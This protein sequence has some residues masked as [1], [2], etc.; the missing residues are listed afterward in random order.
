MLL[1]EPLIILSTPRTYSLVLLHFGQVIL[2]TVIYRF[3]SVC[4]VPSR[5]PAICLNLRIL[6]VC[7]EEDISSGC[8]ER[9]QVILHIFFT[10]AHSSSLSF[11]SNTRLVIHVHTIPGGMLPILRFILSCLF[12]AQS[13]SIVVDCCVKANKYIR[14]K[15]LNTYK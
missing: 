12:L 15:P 4:I 8:I 3:F 1:L 13:L 9:K 5:V 14:E 6:A 10:N 11:R 2:F 7:E